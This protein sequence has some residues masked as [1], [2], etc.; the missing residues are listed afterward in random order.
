[1]PKIFHPHKI[2]CVLAHPDDEAFGPGGAIA[3]YAKSCE[4]H[5]VCV[6][7][8]GAGRSENP[9]DADHLADVRAGEMRSSAQILGVKSLTF[10]GLP[11]GSLNNNNYHEIASRVQEELNRLRPDT[12]LTFDLNGVSGH[13]DHVAVSMITSYLW[14]RLD[15]VSHLLY[16]CEQKEATDMITGKYFIFFP[17]GYHESEVDLVLD[18]SAELETKIKAMRAHVSQKEDCDWI[19]GTMGKKLGQEYFKI[20]SKP[21]QTS[22]QSS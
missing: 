19:I 6:T 17:D 18:V 15:Y 14:E 2:V 8:G 5:I 21:R 13:L 10:L 1:M 11:D 3:H 4:V 12:L 20:K 16:Y 9:A 22:S 7:D